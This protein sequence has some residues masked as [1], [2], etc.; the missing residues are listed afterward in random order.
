MLLPFEPS[1]S[2]RELRVPN[3]NW[4]I[5]DAIKLLGEIQGVQYSSQYLPASVAREEQEKDRQEGGTDMELISSL[6]AGLSSPLVKDPGHWDNN[7]FDF[8]P[9]TLGEMFR[10]FQN[11]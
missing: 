7:K 10:S 3:G 4:K 9:L 8:T 1:E 6:K 5:K 2:V 11:S